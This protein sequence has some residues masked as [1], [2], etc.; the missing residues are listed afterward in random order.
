MFIA[1][2]TILN[3]DIARSILFAEWL[4]ST[5]GVTEQK[6]GRHTWRKSQYPEA[7]KE[8]Q[9]E[10]P[11]RELMQEADY[12]FHQYDADRSRTFR[13]TVDNYR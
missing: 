13:E 7:W 3:T 10:H 12:W 4:P 2:I 11:I 5:S 6:V 1:N 9:D 8:V